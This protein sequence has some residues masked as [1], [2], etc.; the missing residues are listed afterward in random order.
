MPTITA[1]PATAPAK[2]ESDLTAYAAALNGAAALSA[3]MKLAAEKDGDDLINAQRVHNLCTVAEG[4][5]HL[6]ETIATRPAV[7][8]PPKDPDVRRVAHGRAIAADG[9]AAV[10]T[11]V[12]HAPECAYDGQPWCVCRE[13]RLANMGL[14]ARA[15]LWWLVANGVDELIPEP[16]NIVIDHIA[17]TLSIDAFRFTGDVASWDPRRILRSAGRPDPVAPATSS[18]K[19][20]AT[21]APCR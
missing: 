9:S 7:I 5:R 12:S 6:A 21:A 18:A 17:R 11:V 19:R 8:M 4:W 1:T 3:A 16:A 13:G 14:E 10:T 20:S 15:I 2:A